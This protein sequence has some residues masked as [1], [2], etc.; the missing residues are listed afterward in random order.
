MKAISRLTDIKWLRIVCFF[1]AWEGA[2]NLDEKEKTLG[3]KKGRGAKNKLEP[4]KEIIPKL[5]KEKDVVLTIN[6]GNG[7]PNFF[8]EN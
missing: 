3:I 8:E 2:K 6:T 4:V 5:N 7:I 1:N